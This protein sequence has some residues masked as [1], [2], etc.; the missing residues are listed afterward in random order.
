MAINVNFKFKG[1]TTLKEKKKDGY[2]IVPQK[3]ITE[4]QQKQQ[5]ERIYDNPKFDFLNWNGETLSFVEIR[6]LT[7]GK[8]KSD[9]ERFTDMITVMQRESDPYL[10][11]Y[12]KYTT[13][14][15]KKKM[16]GRG[17][18]SQFSEK[19]FKAE[20]MSIISRLPLRKQF[21]L[22]AEISKSLQE[23]FESWREVKYTI[24]G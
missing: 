2:I 23:S 22:I 9:L 11:G 13:K 8:I 4:T 14:N 12:K 3:T 6:S 17:D 19:H 1:E 20:I 24:F 16:V 5:L 7:S 21:R 18:K 10:H 15:G